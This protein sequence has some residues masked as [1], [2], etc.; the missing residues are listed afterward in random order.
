MTLTKENGNYY[1]C[2]P[3]YCRQQVSSKVWEEVKK[4][5]EEVEKLKGN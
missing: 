4:L 3:D 5:Q 2:F 1:I